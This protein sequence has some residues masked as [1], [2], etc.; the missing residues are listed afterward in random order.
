MD[1][2]FMEAQARSNGW[3]QTDLSDRLY[4]TDIYTD[5]HFK[6]ENIIRINDFLATL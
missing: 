1:W 5:L 6:R 2:I 3:K 4:D